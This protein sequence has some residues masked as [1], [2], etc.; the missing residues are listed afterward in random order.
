MFGDIKMLRLTVHTRVAAL[1]AVVALAACSD[2]AEVLAPPRPDIFKSYVA[3]GN[4]I[5][6]G[7][8]SGGINDST[9][10]QSYAFLLAG[11]MGTQY[12]YAA[13]A[14]PGCPAPISQRVDGRARRRRGPAAGVRAAHRQL[15]DGHPEQRRRARP[16][17]FWIRRTT[18][19]STVASNALTTFILGGKTQVQ[20]ALDANPTFVSIWIIGNND[21]LEAGASGVIVPTAGVSPESSALRRSS[22]A[23]YDAM[24]TQL[25]VGAPDVKGVLIG[26]AKVGG[27]FL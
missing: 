12:H 17:A 14:N 3:L 21:V 8:Q 7:Y 10:R 9:Q 19:G 20:R 4:S 1:S 2:K 15:G 27:R 22:Q 6:A 26:V 16:R 25:I 24:I 23:S 5:T 11:R 18:T 13:L